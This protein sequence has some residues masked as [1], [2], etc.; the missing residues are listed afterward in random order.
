MPDRLAR[1]LCPPALLV[2]C[3][4][5]GPAVAGPAASLRGSSSSLDRQ[6][7]QAATHRLATYDTRHDV[8]DAVRRGELV[9]LPG[10]GDYFLKEVSFPYARP[11]IRLFVERLA[12]RYA[13]ECREPLVVT[14]LTRAT[15]M[16]PANASRRSV[17][18]NGIGVDLRRSWSRRCRAWV[19]GVLL[20]LEEA[21]VLEATLEYRPVH[22]HLAIFPRPYRE[23][24]AALDPGESEFLV[25]RYRVARGDTLARIARRHSTT[26]EEV[27]RSNG[28][29]GDLI[30]P[31]QILLIPSSR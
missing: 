29:R 31:G 14:S 19:E 30:R 21:G 28:I 15:R 10:N 9:H 11:E 7:H 18:P 22:Y 13:E 25:L 4:L 23:H 20:T 3:L 5:A 12:A 6:N 24:V 27:R 2:G 26:V 1:T 8:L 17:H 16:Q